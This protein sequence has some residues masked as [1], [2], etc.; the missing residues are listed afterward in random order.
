MATS[1]KEA[2]DKALDENMDYDFAYPVQVSRKEYKE[3]ME[4]GNNE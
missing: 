2:N 1:K 3:Y 4:E